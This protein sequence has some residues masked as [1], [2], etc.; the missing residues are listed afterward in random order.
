MNY[1]RLALVLIRIMFPNGQVYE[2]VRYLGPHDGAKAFCWTGP[3]GD[4]HVNDL[5]NCLLVLQNLGELETA[6]WFINV[7]AEPKGDTE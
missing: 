6:Q 2:N 5:P 7:A 1:F 3:L 4:M